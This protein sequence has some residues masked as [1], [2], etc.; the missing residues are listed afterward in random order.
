MAHPAFIRRA[1]R[2]RKRISPPPCNVSTR[3]SAP[4]TAGPKQAAA[5]I[6]MRRWSSPGREYRRQAATPRSKARCSGTLQWPPRGNGGFGYDPMFQPDGADKTFGEMTSAEKHAY[7]HRARALQQFV[8]ASVRWRTILIPPVSAS[9]CIGRSAPR[10]APIAISTVTYATA[11]SMR[12]GT[13]RAIALKSGPPAAL[14]G[15]RDCIEHFFRRR[16]AFA[17][18]AGDSRGHS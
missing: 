10:N 2:A 16:H 18:G 3:R 8:A 14:I 4:G 7:S 15:P 9:T 5:R 1:G 11:A 17:D 13:W 12:P 6:S